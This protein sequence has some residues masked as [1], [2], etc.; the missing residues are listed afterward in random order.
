M[1]HKQY[2]AVWTKDVEE[3]DWQHYASRDTRSDAMDDVR[4]LHE[5]LEIPRSHIEIRRQDW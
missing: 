2:H 1:S 4:Y 5:S 3:G